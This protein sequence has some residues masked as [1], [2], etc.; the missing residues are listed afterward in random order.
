MQD[1]IES[2]ML[3]TTGAPADHNTHI[4][5]SES[6]VDL[7]KD[8]FFFMGNILWLY[9]TQGLIDICAPVTDVAWYSNK[10]EDT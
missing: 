1:A 7:D 5:L 4:F 3:A 6:H 8:L 9:Q 10:K 2:P